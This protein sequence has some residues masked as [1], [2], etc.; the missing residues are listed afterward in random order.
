MYVHDVNKARLVGVLLFITGNI[1]LTTRFILNKAESSFF[2]LLFSC[3][4]VSSSTSA[5]VTTVT[6]K[7]VNKMRCWKELMILRV[8][9]VDCKILLLLLVQ[10]HPRN[11]KPVNTRSKKERLKSEKCACLLLYLLTSTNS[12]TQS[13]WKRQA[14]R[15]VRNVKTHHHHRS[16]S[17]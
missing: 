7:E 15:R 4:I 16:R 8:W 5:T 1:M 2:A 12:K 6:W 10:F 13:N 9:T 17:S 11:D 14:D 3:I